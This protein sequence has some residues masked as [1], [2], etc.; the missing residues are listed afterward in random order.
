MLFRLPYTL[1]LP[2]PAVWLAATCFAADVT[3]EWD[4]SPAAT[5]YRLYSG[6]S[7]GVYTQT[8]EIGDAT[9]TVVSNLTVGQTYFFIVT[10]YNATSPETAP[11]NEV[12]YTAINTPSPTPTPAPTTTP[13]PAATPGPTETPAPTATPAAASNLNGTVVSSSRIN[14]SW[15]DNSS[16]ES[17]FKIE[18]S[19]NG[20]TFSQIATVAAQTTTYSNIGLAASTKYYYRVRAYNS[21][22]NSAYSNTVSATTLS[23]TSSPT[24][25]PSPTPAPTATPATPPT[26]TPTPTAMPTPTIK[27]VAN[28]RSATEG[29]SVVYTITASNVDRAAARTIYYSMGGTAIQG[30]HYTL[31]G[32][33]GQVT[34]PAGASSATVTL[35]ALRTSFWSGSETA[36]MVL[37][38]GTG[39]KL[40]STY[41]ATIKIYN[42]LN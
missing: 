14:L 11:S 26:P 2:V 21:G 19:T 4:S 37:H 31:S 1:F 7:S 34:I 38:P 23:S 3:L 35:T 30:I 36:K 28:P 22:G 12:A 29:G 9:A 27:V 25:T 32:S 42:T 41:T 24:P 6:T 33:P 5:N 18:R 10:A 8:T 20:I 40:S 17:G 13:V 16:N 15:R 39:Y